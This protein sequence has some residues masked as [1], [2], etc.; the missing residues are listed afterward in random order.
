MIFA[1]DPMVR[2]LELFKENFGQKIA[3]FPGNIPDANTGYLW[4]S[5]PDDHMEHSKSNLNSTG[6]NS[7]NIVVSATG[8]YTIRAGM[9]GIDEVIFDDPYT[10]VIWDDK[11]K[12]TVKCNDGNFKK[13]VGLA[14]AIAR[15][16]SSIRSPYPR[17]Y[18]KKMVKKASEYQNHQK[19]IRT[20]EDVV[21]NF[22]PEQ[23]KVVEAL[24]RNAVAPKDLKHDG[25]DIGDMAI[26]DLDEYLKPLIQKVKSHQSKKEGKNE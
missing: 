17:A 4:S 16:Y 20:V 24:I 5:K 9:P 10:T 7:V 14:F 25:L 23:I 11:T 1:D 2:D 6:T 21:S 22:T 8:D 13:E 19:K 3:V 18:F 26:D 15:K 12:T